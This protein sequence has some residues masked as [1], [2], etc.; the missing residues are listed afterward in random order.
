M[1][2]TQLHNFIDAMLS[3]QLVITITASKAEEQQRLH[4]NDFL[5]LRKCCQ[6]LKSN[7]FFQIFRLRWLPQSNWVV[8]QVST[9]P[10]LKNTRLRTYP[11]KQQHINAQ[12]D[13]KLEVSN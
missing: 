3:W 11:K 8:R 5:I 6:S 9:G 2:L 10:P 4:L 13:F 1:R 12:L 7:T